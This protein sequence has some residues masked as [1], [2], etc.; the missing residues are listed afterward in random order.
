MNRENPA[1]AA[2]NSCAL[3]ACLN[4]HMLD[5]VPDTPS[6]PAALPV[7]DADRYRRYLVLLAQLQLPPALRRR[8][9]ASDLVQQTLLEAH[10]RWDQFRGHESG[11]LLAWLRQIL[12]HNLADAR[13]HALRQKRDADR[14]RSLESLQAVRA[15]LERSSVK[16][17]D[18]LQ[19]DQT[20]PS[21]HAQRH[22]RALRLAD[23]LAALPEAQRD[24]LVLQHWH[25]LSLVQIGEHLG[26]TPAAVAGLL[27]RGLKQLRLL[28]E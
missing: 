6:P 17:E 26:K 10:Q 20:S 16:L 28:M 15:D 8:L 18:W 5:P 13:R 25:G 11:E 12:A 22:E 14:D 7:L 2:P 27:K 1:D 19:A 4:S 24:A 9:D 23:A 21:L 3:V